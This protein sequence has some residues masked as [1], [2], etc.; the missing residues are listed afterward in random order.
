MSND[1]GLRK[2]VA[3]MA[4]F[5]WH[6]R[7]GPV[8]GFVA[9]AVTLITANWTI[10]VSAALGIAAATWGA[11]T[12]F[13]E[14][15]D[16]EIGIGVFLVT[17][18]TCVGLTILYDRRWPR[19]VQTHLDYRYGLTFE[20]LLPTFTPTSAKVPGAGALGF[21]ISLRNYS[22]GPL[23]YCME[24]VDIRLGTRTIP[25]YKLNAVTGNISSML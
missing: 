4:G 15:Q 1:F 8:G 13:F 6:Q 23:D 14:R 12:S 22:P 16:V 18:W 24:S 5:K 17:L 20:G 11:L 19:K 9:I 7:L 3:Q 10:A 21:S 25:K 2:R